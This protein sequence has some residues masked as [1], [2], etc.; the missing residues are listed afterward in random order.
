MN[1]PSFDIAQKLI[2]ENVVAMGN[3]F[4]G[5]D[6]INHTPAYVTLTDFGGSPTNPKWLRDNPNVQVRVRGERNNYADAYE[7]IK[8]VKNNLLG[9]KPFSVD[10]VIYARFV[11]IS[12]ILFLGYD[13]NNRPQFSI[14]FQLTIDYTDSTGTNREVIQ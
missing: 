4:V 1:P 9:K 13:P 12:D 2:E 7:L 6:P 8:N 10:E 3:V 11:L 5:S 14:N